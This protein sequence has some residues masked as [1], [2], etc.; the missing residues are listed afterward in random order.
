MKLDQIFFDFLTKIYLKKHPN[1]LK[2]INHF[3]KIPKTFLVISNTALGDLLLSTPAIKSLKNSFPNSKIIALI[4]KNYIP[5]MKNFP[6]IDEIIPYYGGYKKFFKIIKNIKKYKPS[7]AFIFHGNGPQDI[8]I[9]IFSGCEFILKHP[10]KSKLKKYLSFD[11]KKKKQH[12]IEDRLDLIRKIGANK[13]NT[14]MEIGDLNN[15]KYLKQFKKYKNY[16]GFQIGA[17]DKYKIWPIENFIIIA[18]YLIKKGKKIIITGI[19]KEFKFG[20]KIV[21]E[22]GKENVINMCGKTTIEELPYLIKNL[23]LLITNDTGTMHLAIALKI[24]TISLFAATDPK[25]IGPYQDLNIHKVVYKD[26][27]FI[28]K[29]PKKQRDNSA[30]KLINVEDVIK[31]YKELNENLSL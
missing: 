25:G 2:K 13:I 29:F 17:A 15:E 10:T 23:K 21:N 22:C 1:Q 30:M 19:D 11:F 12:T 14:L 16:I 6:Y 7:M 26:G 24:P 8:Q 18:K 4:N 28:Q 5:L 9:A 27:S 3:D 20:E 31:A